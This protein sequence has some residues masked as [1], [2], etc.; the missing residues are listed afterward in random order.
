[1][2]SDS[3]TTL[4]HRI[5]TAEPMGD[6]KPTEIPGIGTVAE[7]KFAAHDYDFAYQIFG[8]YLVLKKDVEDFSEFLSDIGGMNASNIKRCVECVDAWSNNFF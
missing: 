2:S 6:K 8:E 3:S 5:F 1:M 7:K 4:K